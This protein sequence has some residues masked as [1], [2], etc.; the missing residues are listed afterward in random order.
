M[1]FQALNNNVVYLP[2]LSFCF[3]AW[4]ILVQVYP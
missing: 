2:V 4:N 3:F 1:D